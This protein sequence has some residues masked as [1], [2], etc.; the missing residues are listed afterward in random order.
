MPNWVYCTTHI[1]GP[2]EDMARFYAAARKGNR[3]HLKQDGMEDWGCFTDIQLES[4]MQ[5]ALEYQA[6]NNK[7]DFSFHSLYPVPIGVQVMPYDPHSFHE[8]LAKNPAIAAF[9]QKHDVTMAGYDWEYANWGTKWGDC[10]T[11]VYDVSDTHM[12]LYFETAWSAPHNFW[13]KVSA[14][15][16]TLTFSMSYEEEMRQFAGEAT[17]E[18]GEASIDE[19]EPEYD[20]EDESESYN[21]EAVEV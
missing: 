3:F 7:D 11:E 17:Y 19:W 2:A 14:D 16:P 10:N 5:E 9:C 20:S 15:Y 18:A 6:A 8:G 21:E 1:T 4:L 12:N 13:K